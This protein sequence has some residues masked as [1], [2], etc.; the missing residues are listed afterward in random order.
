MR[1]AYLRKMILGMAV[2]WLMFGW[3]SIAFSAQIKLAWDANG[4]ADL[5]GYK[6][7]HGTSSG[8]YGTPTNVGK[9]TSYTLTGL[10]TGQ[11]YYIAVTAY[12]SSSNESDLSDEISGVAKDPSQTVAITIAANTAG[13]QITVD[14]TT[15]TA[16]QTFNWTTGS[17]HTIGVSS[18]QSGASGTRY[19]YSNWSDGGAQT[20]TITVPS[21]AATY[22]TNFTTQHSLTTSVNPSGAGTVSPS[23]TS[24][25]NSGQT[26]SLSAS[27]GGGYTFVNWSGDLTGSSNPASLTMSG[28]RNVVANFSAIPET[29]SAPSTPGGPSSGT[30]GVA[31]TY[32][33]GGSTSNLGHSIQ[34]RFD[35]GD[36]T[37]S[38]WS[39]STSASKT[40]P[41]I[42]TYSVRA[43]ARCATHTSVESPWS[44][45]RSVVVTQGTVS[46]TVATTPAGLRITVDETSYDAPHTFNWTPGA[47]RQLSVSSPQSG[48]SGTRY[49]YS[50][51]SDGG[52]QT[53]TITVPSSAATYT[54]NFTTQHSLTTSVNPSGAGTVS[55]SGTNWYN[56]GQ[57]VSLSASAGGGYTFVNWSGDLTG[58]SNPA[59]LTMSGPR[60]V[61]ANF[62][63]PSQGSLVVT[64][65]DSVSSSGNKG[66][67]F[68]PSSHVFTLQNTSGT[69]FNWMVSKSQ[70]WSSLS[71]E[72][73]SL[74]PGAS[75]T[76]TVSI[77]EAANTLDPGSYSDA[78][79]FTNTSNNSG[80]TTRSVNLTVSAE[81]LITHRIDSHPT[82]REVWVDG[83]PHKTP[84]KFK[85]QSGSLHTVSTVDSQEGA[86]GKRFRFS[87]WSDG[88]AVTHTI[89][90]PLDPTTYTASFI[91]EFSLETSV[92]D[93]SRG[94]LNL[95]GLQ[96]Y[97][98]GA[99]VSLTGV[100][101]GG[102]KFKNWK[103]SL[104]Q[105][106]GKDNPFSVTMNRP[107]KIKA[108]FAHITYPLTVTKVPPGGGRVSRT[109]SKSNYFHGEQVTLTAKPKYGYT[110]V[111]WGGDTTG[112]ESTV[113]ITVDSQ[114]TVTANFTADPEVP[115]VAATSDKAETRMPLIGQLESPG[116]GKT[117]SGVKPIYGWALDGEAV[118]KVELF[119]DGQYVCQIPYGG[120]RE[121]IREAHAKY[122]GAEQAGFA[123]VWNYSVLS[124]GEHMVGIRVHNSGGEAL[125]LSARVSVIKFHGDVVTDMNPDTPTTCPVTVTADGVTRTYDVNLQWD[126]EIQDFSIIDIVP[127]D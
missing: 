67:P 91:V 71:Q 53:H 105:V 85:W 21:S 76:V 121:D 118:T 113:T 8:S 26:V 12:D 111:G 14:G 101:A 98:K 38:N 87:S 54:A 119:I 58:S 100:P 81:A 6:V 97:E 25:Y 65:S 126:S 60:N 33:T 62:T 115:Q 56:S 92:N 77:N 35:W 83:V 82:G 1:Y 20:H 116:D 4:E 104:G 30:T 48:T 9:V 34:Y 17:S 47:A 16:P 43:Q 24:W 37:Y 18:P 2:L 27:A 49:I 69:S 90:A 103:N 107:K 79:K 36:S 89:T 22:T 70:S 74:L 64:P 96:W 108:N 123:L 29:V 109:P 59:S 72:T 42:G 68:G 39:S 5:A 94:T 13:R 124:A 86:N 41:S 31:Y 28:P 10:T 84:K 44:N 88:G 45:A 106:V 114:K 93:E 32:T 120:L 80:D 78:I 7:Y 125:D 112:A 73:G 102:Y 110:F 51:W 95:S 55:P 11:T 75:T 57:T 61:V 122:P 99:T 23:G 46:C 63:A 52:A 15:L 40:W 19:I 127:K 50:N 3:F 66:G 117:L